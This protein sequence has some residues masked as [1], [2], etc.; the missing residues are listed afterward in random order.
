MY[1]LLFFLHKSGDDLLL[2]HFRE[3]TLKHLSDITESE[4][5]LAKV[6]S[7]LLLDTKYSYYCEAT[8]NSKN[9]MDKRMSSKAGKALNKDL[10]DF[11]EQLT[12]IAVNYGE[13]N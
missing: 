7:N 4:V 8:A 2:Q 12:V 13:E 6:E 3:F 10:M 11:H 1:K 9:E 5:K